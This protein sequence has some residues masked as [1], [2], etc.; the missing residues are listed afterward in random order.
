MGGQAGACT[1]SVG[2]RDKRRTAGANTV[3]AGAMASPLRSAFPHTCN[4]P[5][6]GKP[7]HQPANPRLYHTDLR[8]KAIHLRRYWNGWRTERPIVYKREFVGVTPVS[9]ISIN[10]SLS[11][12]FASFPVAYASPLTWGS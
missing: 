3:Q 7:A 2:A 12:R 9:P 5:A 4:A 8:L 1:G 10:R 6:A 11:R